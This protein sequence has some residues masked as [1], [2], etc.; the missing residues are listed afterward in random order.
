MSDKLTYTVKE[1]SQLLGMSLP[2]VYALCET[3]DFPSIR[4][5]PRRIVIP[6]DALQ[7]WLDEQAKK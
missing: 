2:N 4:V 1:V 7:N 5:S 6:K 3:K